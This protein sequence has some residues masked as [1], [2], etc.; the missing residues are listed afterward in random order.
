LKF[1]T[2]SVSTGR[3]QKFG[4]FHEKIGLASKELQAK[5]Y[6]TND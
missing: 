5:T 1:D 3:E 6:L 4:I 2:F